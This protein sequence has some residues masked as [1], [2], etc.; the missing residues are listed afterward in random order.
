VGSERTDVAR[1]EGVRSP[2]DLLAAVN[3]SPDSC[4]AEMTIE[5]ADFSTF[6]EAN[7]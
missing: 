6:P 5:S 1:F 4:A 7:S 2:E 3:G